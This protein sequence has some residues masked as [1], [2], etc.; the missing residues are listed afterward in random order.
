ME[1]PD[2]GPPDAGRSLPV[3]QLTFNTKPKLLM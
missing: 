2:G 3:D 1:V